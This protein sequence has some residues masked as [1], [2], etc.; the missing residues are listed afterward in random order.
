M[1]ATRSVAEL[2]GLVSSAEKCG[3]GAVRSIQVTNDARKTICRASSSLTAE[4]G[5]AKTRDALTANISGWNAEKGTAEQRHAERREKLQSAM[6]KA[7]ADLAD[8]KPTKQANSDAAALVGYLAAV[9]VDAIPDVVNKWL[10]ILACLSSKWAEGCRRQSAWLL[11]TAG[12]V[13]VRRSGRTFRPND[14]C[15]NGRPN[16]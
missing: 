3:P 14:Q 10:V 16:P 6:D 2:S 4:L 12:F 5:R 9:G 15:A 11:V 7:A 8:A 1:P 13:Q